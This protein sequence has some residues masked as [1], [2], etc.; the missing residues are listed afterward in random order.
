MAN[1]LFTGFVVLATI[2]WAM[3]L[4]MFAPVAFAATSFSAGSLIKSA[5]NT[6]VY[7]YGSDSK[8]YV[9]PH[10]KYYKTWYPDF[11]NIVTVTADEMAA[12]EIGGNV[13]VRPGTKLVKVETAPAVYAVE[14][15]SKL[16]KIGSEAAA[17]TLYGNDWAKNVMDL[18]D[19]LY[20]NYAKQTGELDGTAYPVG[21]VVKP[22]GD[23]KYYVSASGW[24]KIATDDA[25]VANKFSTDNVASTTMAMIIIMTILPNRVVLR[26]R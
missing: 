22:A 12:I 2:A 1:K 20:T 19:T 13:S 14:P 9:F 17:K 23:Y 10:E 16:K 21:A 6:A 5:T 3:G 7:Y 15:G 4:A 8:R 18:Y 24:R 26:E 25:F 11:K